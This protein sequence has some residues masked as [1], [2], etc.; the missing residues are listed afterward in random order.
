MK[1]AGEAEFAV[2]ER[3]LRGGFVKYTFIIP[4]AISASLQVG[5]HKTSVPLLGI[6][7]NLVVGSL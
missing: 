2:S 5:K 1:Y 4:F 6:G 3:A 7:R